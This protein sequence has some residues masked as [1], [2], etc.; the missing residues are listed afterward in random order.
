M[1]TCE[2]LRLLSVFNHKEFSTVLVKFQPGSQFIRICDISGH[3]EVFLI[4]TILQKMGFEVKAC[5]NNVVRYQVSIE[6]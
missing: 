2:T 3:A 6:A 5:V 1:A 4:K